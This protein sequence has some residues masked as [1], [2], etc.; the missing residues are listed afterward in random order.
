MTIPKN[1]LL[2][3]FFAKQNHC[4]KS[5]MAK[6]I[7]GRGHFCMAVSF[8][9]PPHSLSAGFTRPVKPGANCPENFAL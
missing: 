7:C 4:A 6:L 3:I 8:K 1:W 5:I 9:A 2:S